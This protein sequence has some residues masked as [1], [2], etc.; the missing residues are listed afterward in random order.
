MGGTS[1]LAIGPRTVSN[2]T[3]D[4]MVVDED[5][6]SPGTVGKGLGQI[7]QALASLATT[8]MM[9]GDGEHGEGKQEDCDQLTQAS[10]R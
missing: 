5:S 7:K 9:C 6:A 4:H 10:S 8:R 1:S 2:T 3:A